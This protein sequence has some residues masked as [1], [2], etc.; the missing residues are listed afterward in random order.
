MRS[1]EEMLDQIVEKSSLNADF[2]RQFPVDPK[3]A[4]HR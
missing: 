3:A 2:R 4:S 1:G